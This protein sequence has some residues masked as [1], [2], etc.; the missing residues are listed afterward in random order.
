VD[1]TAFYSLYDHLQSHDLGAPY[2]VNDPVQPYRVIPLVSM[3]SVS[4]RTAGLEVASKMTVTSHWR[5]AASGSLFT[6]R[7]RHDAPGGGT[8]GMARND[9]SPSHALSFQSSLDLPH[10]LEFDTSFYSV[11]KLAGANV[12]G[13]NRLDVRVGW[14]PSKKYELSLGVQ[15][16]L[17]AGHK[18]FGWDSGVVPSSIDRVIYGK[19]VWRP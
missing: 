2:L 14:H 8:V 15:N 7:F 18:E 6:A 1:T 4:A 5:L 19:F 10:H 13:Y 16:L 12:P 3:N 9:D 11:G 17:G